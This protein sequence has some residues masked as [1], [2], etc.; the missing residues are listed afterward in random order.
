MQ[1]KEPFF[2]IFQDSWL[3]EEP[4]FA[5]EYSNEYKLKV[6][7]DLGE[8]Y[9]WIENDEGIF[10]WTKVHKYKVKKIEDNETNRK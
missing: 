3:Q 4:M 10:E 7:E 1:I 8:G 2:T 5:E 9:D 6:L